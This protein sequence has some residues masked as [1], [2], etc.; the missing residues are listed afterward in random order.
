MFMNDNRQNS[1]RTF[2]RAAALAAAVL[3]A[4]L[5]IIT[6]FAALT[7]RPGAAFLFRVCLVLTV[8]VPTVLW[9]VIRVLEFT[10]KDG[11]DSPE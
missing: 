3:L 6:L 4:G 7:A 1:P 9:I 5:Y 10:R 8:M 2:K 11:G